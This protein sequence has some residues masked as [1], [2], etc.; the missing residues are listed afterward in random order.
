MS[1]GMPNVIFI[2][3]S[4]E[5]KTFYTVFTKRGRKH[6]DTEEAARAFEKKYYK[7]VA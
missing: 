6:F 5:G 2:E 7:E 1:R 4:S 3:R